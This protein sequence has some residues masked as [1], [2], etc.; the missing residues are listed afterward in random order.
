MKHLSI[1]SLLIIS[2]VGCSSNNTPT[3][4]KLSQDVR[5]ISNNTSISVTSQQSY[6]VPK[7]AQIIEET[8][9][10]RVIDNIYDSDGYN[11][12]IPRGALISGLY[13]ND[14]L[15]CQIIWKSIY[16]NKDEYENNRGT[17]AL[18]QLLR[19]LYVHPL[20]ELNKVNE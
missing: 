16:V 4:Q 9:L 3:P 14:G 13:T 10:Y 17:L 11:V 1:I 12:L 8:G 7:D 18:V 2:L 6:S 20:V 15:Q 19:H 5:S